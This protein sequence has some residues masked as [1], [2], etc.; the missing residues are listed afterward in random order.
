M[1]TIGTSLKTLF[2]GKK[3]GADEFGNRYYTNRK[4]TRRWVIYKGMDEA[5][6]V[7]AAWHRWLHKTSDEIPSNTPDYAWEK[8][9]L[10][11]LSGTKMAYL[12]K[13]HIKSGGRRDKATGDYEAWKP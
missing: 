4:K 1:A 5:S 12:P 6:K 3:V 7:P 13:G 2:C 10:P 8:P 9:H 11:N